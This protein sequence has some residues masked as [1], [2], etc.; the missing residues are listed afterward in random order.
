MKQN[1][2]HQSIFT[3]LNHRTILPVITIVLLLRFNFVPALSAAEKPNI[4][5]IMSDDHAAHAISAY[6]SKV[7]KTPQL[8]R[9][10]SEGIRFDNCFVTNSLCA[11][12]RAVILTG[13][14]SHINGCRPVETN[15]RG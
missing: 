12:G 10:A 2:S 15:T 7:N 9:L 11:P 8:D 14:Y 6:G 3:S 1:S 4:I 13:K 5:F